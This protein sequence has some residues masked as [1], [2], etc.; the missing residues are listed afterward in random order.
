MPQSFKANGDIYP[1]RFV[2]LTTTDGRVV[3]CGAGDRGI[4]VS[5][6]STR[7]SD[8]VD[9]SGKAAASGEPIQV[10]DLG[11][12]CLLEIAGTVAQGDRLKS[13]AN[14]KGVVTTTDRDQYVAVALVSG[15]S[16]EQ[17]KVKVQPGEVSL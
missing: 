12:E 10:Y 17:I 2:K 13:D 8:Y 9:S 3:Q 11:E 16:G 14:G 5:Q 7:R 15:V 6:M 4:G 1:A